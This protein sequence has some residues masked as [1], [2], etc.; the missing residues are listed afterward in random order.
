[1]RFCVLRFEKVPI[2]HSD[3]DVVDCR[4][5]ETALVPSRAITVVECPHLLCLPRG[6]TTSKSTTCHLVHNVSVDIFGASPSCSCHDLVVTPVADGR[7]D[8]QQHIMVS[9]VAL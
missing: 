8:G 1:V 3:D 9:V 4:D 7:G 5:H 6:P 2:V